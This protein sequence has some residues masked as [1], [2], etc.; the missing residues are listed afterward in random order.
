[1]A[2]CFKTGLSGQYITN[3]SFRSNVRSLMVLPCFP[4]TSI[5]EVFDELRNQIAMDDTDSHTVYSY[6]EGVWFDTFPI[7]IW[8]QNNESFSTNNVAESFHAALSMR[9]Q[10][11]HPQFHL[12]SRQVVRITNESKTRLEEER[13]HPKER[14]RCAAVRRKIKTNTEN[15]YG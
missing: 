7:S 9:I 11:H 2:V 15:N 8:C 10:H 5:K 6:F 13:L 12:F 4:E 3:E 14:L 1:M